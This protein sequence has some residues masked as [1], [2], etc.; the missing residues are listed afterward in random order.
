MVSPLLLGVCE[1]MAV[2]RPN[3]N[4]A[5][6]NAMLGAAGIT[7]RETVVLPV[8]PAFVAV[9]VYVATAAR[10]IGVPLITHR[11][12]RSR[13][14]GSAGETEHDVIVSPEFEGVWGA[15]TEFRLKEKGPPVKEMTGAAA[16]LPFARPAV[17]LASI[18]EAGPIGLQPESARTA[19][20]NKYLNLKQ[21]LPKFIFSIWAR[22]GMPYLHI[23]ISA[24]FLN[25]LNKLREVAIDANSPAH[26][27]CTP[28]PAHPPL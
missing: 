20:G 5:F 16:V 7:A 2:V 23:G 1:V 12:E 26:Y 14:A 4:G 8:P 25:D 11:L 15:I 17:K 21:K 18:V 22:D 3:E 10:K 9:I 13:P 6:P 24:Q 27:D 19:I 28:C